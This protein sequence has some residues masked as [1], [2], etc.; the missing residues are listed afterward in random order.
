MAEASRVST[1]DRAFL[2]MAFK[3]IAPRKGVSAKNAHV[4]SIT[5]V[6]GQVSSGSKKI[7]KK[8]KKKKFGLTSQHMPL[9]VLGMQVGFVAIWTRKF[10]IGVFRGDR[11]VSGRA[12]RV[13]G[14]H[15]GS[16]RRTG[17]YTSSSL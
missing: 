11:C 10:P 13:F 3:D 15:S 7:R 5:G 12:I 8:K 1:T 16:S 2:E 17:Q 14:R 9:Q 6:Y 4:R